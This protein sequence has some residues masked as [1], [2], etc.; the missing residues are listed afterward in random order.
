VLLGDFNALRR[1]DVPSELWERIK[2]DR[3]RFVPASSRLVPMMLRKLTALRITD[4]GDG[5]G[6]AAASSSR[7][8][9]EPAPY[10][11]SSS[12]AAAEPAPY[13][14]SSSRTA[15]ELDIGYGYSDSA[16]ESWSQLVAVAVGDKSSSPVSLAGA[17]RQA[18]TLLRHQRSKEKVNTKE[19]ACA[20]IAAAERAAR[21]G[22]SAGRASR[23]GWWSGRSSSG[24]T[25]RRRSWLAPAAGEGEGPSLGPPLWSTCRLG[26]RIDHVLLH[27]GTAPIPAPTT[28]TGSPSTSAATAAATD[29]A[30]T[31]AGSDDACS[32]RD[33]SSLTR[34]AQPDATDE[35]V[36]AARLQAC[37][38]RLLVPRVVPGSYWVNATDCS[39]H[40]IVICDVE[41][42]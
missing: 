8:A 12:R 28:P 31:R 23:D 7:A 34:D 4:D 41:L 29:T 10:P 33:W 2:S 3:E 18:N 14:M 30:D 6:S 11:M 24:R 42:V 37:R 15:A 39:D 32:D 5:A 36:A 21:R 22:G 19:E 1:A 27:P 25:Q 17:I 35:L 20:V 9:A 26:T 13:P 16:R 40:D 38:D